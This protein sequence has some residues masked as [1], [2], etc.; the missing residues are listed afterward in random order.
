MR[1]NNAPMQVGVLKILQNLTN[2]LRDMARHCAMDAK[3]LDAHIL[4]RMP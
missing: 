1:G 4:G 2:N 3:Y